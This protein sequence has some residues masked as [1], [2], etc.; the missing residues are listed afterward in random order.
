MS[1]T[2][3]VESICQKF[4]SLQRTDVE[5]VNHKLLF[6]HEEHL[7][8]TLKA[9]P[10]LHTFADCDDPNQCIIDY[11]WIV[12]KNNS[13]FIILKKKDIPYFIVSGPEGICN[14]VEAFVTDDLQLR[15]RK[16]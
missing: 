5:F 16:V 7:I 14:D 3:N 13:L 12:Q 2:V 10:I 15:R 4:Y 11:Y 1:L 8:T 6:I 9:Q